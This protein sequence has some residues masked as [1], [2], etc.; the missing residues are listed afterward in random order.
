MEPSP[1]N[2]RDSKTESRTH[3]IK[4]VWGMF[5]PVQARPLNGFSDPHLLALSSP[6][7]LLRNI[8][9]PGK[10]TDIEYVPMY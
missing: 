3:L 10:G 5:S 4:E 2:Q 8:N 9:C 7:L 1:K 6:N